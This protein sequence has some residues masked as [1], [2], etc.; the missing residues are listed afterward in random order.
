MGVADVRGKV[1]SGGARGPCAAEASAT[2]RGYWVSSGLRG[3]CD[4]VKMV[5]TDPS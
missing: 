5:F 4:L 2:P 1:E 3:L